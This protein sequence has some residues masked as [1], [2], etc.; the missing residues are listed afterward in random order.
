MT[1]E[2][3]VLNNGYVGDRVASS[4]VL[5]R[6]GGT[7]AVVDPGMVA[8]RQQILAPMRALGID[9]GDVTD[10]VFSHHHPD[11]TINAALFL[12]ARYHDH[13]AYYLDDQWVSRDAEGF[14]LT[15]SIRLI[16]TPG[17][18]AEDITTLVDTADGLVAL[19]HVWWHSGGP[20]HDPRAT[21]A[22]ALTASRAR[23]LA[24][25][26]SLIVPGHGSPFVPDEN[27]PR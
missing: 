23:V 2:L 20:V 24:L 26:P 19:T 22:D 4:V 21:D 27:T 5:L 13:W 6:D 7:L 17:H 9:P 16:R 10:V 3:W 25:R 8:D 15:D 11:H 18:T 14:A 12:N 1:A